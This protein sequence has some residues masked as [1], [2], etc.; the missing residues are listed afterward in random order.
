MARHGLRVAVIGAGMA[1]RA[2]AAGYRYLQATYGDAIPAVQPVAVADKDPRLAADLASRFGF[3]RVE[4]SWEPIAEAGDIDAVSVVLPNSEHWPVVEALLARGKAVLCEKPLARTA[5]EA[6]AM[7]SAADA[8]GAVAQ[9]AFTHRFSPAVAAVR[10]LI[11]A[12]RIGQPHQLISRYLSDHGRDPEIPFSWRHDLDLAGGGSL[13]DIGAHN[14]DVARFLCGDV[15]AIRGAALRTRIRQRHLALG[16]TKGHERT[17]L[18]EETREVTN[19]DEATFIAEFA[20]GC[21]GTFVTSRIATGFK[22]S[23]GFVLIGSA[24]SA[25]FDWERVAEFSFAAGDA[26]PA[27]EGFTRVLVGPQHPY[28]AEGLVMPVAGVGFGLADAFIFQAADFVMAA[29]AGTPSRLGA[30]FADG[31]ANALVMDAVKRSAAA[32]GAEVLLADER[33]RATRAWLAARGE[34]R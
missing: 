30:G 24:G 10:D 27:V 14:L 29:A 4:T 34:G 5:P 19:D 17:A 20:S 6:M 26:D 28:L 9:V 12:G 31:V 22:N 25:Q 2:H 23:S 18:S 16:T 7:E 8:S 11:D 1:G 15:V 21:I 33:E 3:E 13:V 32:G